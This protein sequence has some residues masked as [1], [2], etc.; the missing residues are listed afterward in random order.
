MR[1]TKETAFRQVADEIVSGV[2]RPGTAL[3]ERSLTERFG[4]SRTPIREVLWQLSQEMLIDY[5]PKQGAFVRRLTA[6]DLVD[7][8]QLRESVETLAS[9]LAALN[10]P[11]DEATALLDRLESAD[12]TTLGAEKLGGLGEELHNA[13][14]KW[15]GNRLLA[16]V[17]ETLH[18]QAQLIR[19]MTRSRLEVEQQSYLEH[20]HILECVANGDGPGAAEAM[21][22]HLQRSSAAVM[23]ILVHTAADLDLVPTIGVEK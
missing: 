3:T 6:K 13:L 14:V 2:L 21:R 15:S 18:L 1:Y 4:L 8:F 12:P 20:L 10:R 11:V 5:Y 7:V 22:S 16:K 19:G 17:Y 9:Y 23:E